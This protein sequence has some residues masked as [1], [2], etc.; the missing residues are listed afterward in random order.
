MIINIS[1]KDPDA[2]ENACRE[3][4]IAS[5]NKLEGLSEDERETIIDMR[6]SEYL[7]A[8]GKWFADNEYVDLV[9]DTEAKTCTLVTP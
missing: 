2:L 1:F 6:I 3:A 9:V 5:V 4:A 7:E 8:C